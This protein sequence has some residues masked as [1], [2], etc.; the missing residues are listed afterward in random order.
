MLITYVGVDSK[1][2][3]PA[4][5]LLPITAGFECFAGYLLSVNW[6][7]ID[8][9]RTRVLARETRLRGADKLMDGLALRT[10]GRQLPCAV[11]FEQPEHIKVHLVFLFEIN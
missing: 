10:D 6:I 5:L 2:S 1:A 4:P 3:S 7:K 11:S 9:L 8:F